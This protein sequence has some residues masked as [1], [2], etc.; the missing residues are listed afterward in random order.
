MKI[1]VTGGAGYIGSVTVK[2]LLKQGYEVVVFDNLSQG[3]KAGDFKLCRLVVGDLLDKK[4]LEPLKA[5]K[6]DAVVHFAALALAGESMEKPAKYF[7]NNILGGLN[8]L[9]FMRGANIP[10]IIFSSTCAVYGTPDKVPVTENESKKPESVYGES[11]LAFEKI[12]YWYDQLYSIRHI[13]LRYFNACGAAI[14]GSSGEEHQPET[15]IIPLAIFAALENK[16]FPIFGNDYPTPDKTCVRD[17]IHIEDLAEAHILAMK[18]L[19]ATNKSDAFNLGTGHGYSNME[20][21]NMVKE[22][23]GVD[24]PVEIEPRRAG[25]PAIIYADNA[26][27]RTQL[28]FDPKYSDLETIVKSAYEWHK[29]SVKR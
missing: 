3:Q 24:F 9:E 5:E 22:I 7:E 20:V 17:Y 15:H 8:L 29:K 28:G 21:V 13:N 26:K 4:S 14:D 18:K 1:L 12:L 11:K 10:S 27:A 23:T 6:F 16:P 2:R 25:D 19:S